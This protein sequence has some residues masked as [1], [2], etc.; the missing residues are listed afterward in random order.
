[1]KMMSVLA[2]CLAGAAFGAVPDKFLSYIETDKSK[3]QF[4]DTGVRAS[5]DMCFTCSYRALSKVAQ[6]RLFGAYTTTE[7]G[8]DV[9]RFAV[10]I[11]GSQNWAYLCASPLATSA[12]YGE[13]VNSGKSADTTR[14]HVVEVDFPARSFKLTNAGGDGVTYTKDMSNFRIT[15]NTETSGTIYLSAGN[16]D[17]EAYLPT[18]MR[19][20]S[21]RIE[22]GGC[23]VR[24]YVP[25][26]KDGKVGLWDFVS[27]ELFTD[28]NGNDL[29]GGEE[30]AAPT[31][32]LSFTVPDGGGTVQGVP[33]SVSPGDRVTLTAV[34][35]EGWVFESWTGIPGG[36]TGK[37]TE[38]FFAPSGETTVSARFRRVLYVAET[39]GAEASGTKED[40]MSLD[41]ALAA[42]VDYDRTLVFLATGTYPRTEPVALSNDVWL[43]GE[44]GNPADVTVRG[45][46]SSKTPFRVFNISK[47]GTKIDSL[48]VSGGYIQNNGTYGAGVYMTGGTV[49]N[50]IITGNY[51]GGK[52]SRCAGIYMASAGCVVSHCVITNNSTARQTD[53]G[54][55][56]T[57]WSAG[58]TA[59]AMVKSGT[60]RNCLIAGNTA[61]KDNIG[62]IVAVHDGVF[63]NNTVADNVNTAVDGTAGVLASGG[64]VINCLIAG[65]TKTGTTPQYAEWRGS[66]DLFVNCATELYR[67]NDTC[68]CG[69]D[70]GFLD[71]QNRDYRLSSA[72]KCRDAGQNDDR[73]G[74]LDLL[75]EKR[76]INKII[77]IGCYEF[78]NSAFS[79]S[80]VQSAK[81]GFSP[82]TVVF[83][84]KVDGVDEGDELEYSWF[85][86]G[87][88]RQKSSEPTF[89]SDF[90]PGEYSV[91]LVAANLT[92]QVTAE[93]YE[94]AGAVTCGAR[95]LYVVD[96]NPGAAFPYDSFS[97]AASTVQMA[98]DAAL[99]GADICISNGTYA[100]ATAVSVNHPVVLHGLTGV[101]EDVILNGQG[102]TGCL[103][104]SAGADALVH[105]L[106]LHR[107]GGASV[108]GGC[109]IH[110]RGGTVS[111]LVIRNCSQSGKWTYGG[112]FYLS[113]V[114]SHM[115]H[116]VVTNCTSS[117]GQAD[118]AYDHGTAGDVRAGATLAHTL[119]ANC[120]TGSSG[121]WHYDS[122]LV[123]GANSRIS[124]CTVVD[125]VATNIAGINLLAASARFDHCLIAGNR[126]SR[127][128][129]TPRWNVWGALYDPSTQGTW[130]ESY[131]T[132][133][134]NRVTD[135]FAEGKVARC[136]SD[137]VAITAD[138]IL[139][140][141]PQ[142]VKVRRGRIGL[143]AN[144]PAANAVDPADVPGMPEKDVYGNP[145]LFGSKYDIGAVECQRFGGLLL[146][147]R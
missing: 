142:L 61:S 124:F 29:V 66:A 143:P 85:V 18:S 112:G 79:A 54:T 89:S 12:T 119:V 125:N 28:G 103:D 123:V 117:S 2:V 101:A 81:T 70:I 57:D 47:A 130:S 53:A 64:K 11:N 34:P 5:D 50:C 25:A 129:E 106:V 87:V 30:T 104:I 93:P 17:G 71:H 136:A 52:T 68:Y 88:L 145:R 116:C 90:T 38:D 146:L 147:V 41:A 139:A 65:N 8:G 48:T 140:D 35:A 82:L 107:G 6:D 83:T 91:K 78:D 23:V 21:C 44:T 36:V 109:Y 134:L 96:G 33:E 135:G 31:A 58:G 76:V 141:Y 45:A 121:S 95:Q 94:I 7:T 120:R 84:A 131:R 69:P 22:R 15:K 13:W 32:T 39:G 113:G 86:D 63:I 24:D 56:I 43:V 19:I 132:E 111:N 102:K 122:T 118:G 115:T 74:S 144:S 72:S 126:S 9:L 108:C 27:G 80:F 67:I 110:Q 26:E 114:D 100:L 42:A 49:T 97:N 62:A 73:A 138:S 20:Y 40:P 46:Y 128:N 60:V 59:L 137:T 37:I 105:S 10:Y 98:I 3:S 133:E 77:D 55:S 16:V 4:I 99:D 92:K 127:G 1:M 75:G 14:D 51:C